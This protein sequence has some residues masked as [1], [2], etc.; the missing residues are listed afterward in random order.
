LDDDLASYALG[1]VPVGFDPA[2]PVGTG[3]FRRNTFTPGDR[4]SFTR[5]DG[6][7][8]G[9][10]PY[11]DELVI[12]D[13]PDDNARVT[14][15][16]DGTVDAIDNIAQSRADAVKAA[17]ANLLVSETGSWIPFTMRVDTAP[18]SDVR[19]RQ[20]LRLI[21]DREEMVNRALNGQGRPGNDL[22]APFDPAYA[23]ELPQRRQDIDQA[24][25]LLRQ[26]G[27]D[28]LA[29]ELKT[30]SGIG[31]GAVEAAQLFAKQAA[32]AGVTVRVDTV[33]SAT[34]YGKDYLAWGFV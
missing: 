25:S 22:Y 6:Y 34:F 5:F 28:S 1:I 17:G 26:A 18:F 32:A 27:Q 8:R 20:A 10:Q 15:L 33:D 19:V 30:S 13:Y 2:K 21:V 12:I 23:R 9:D 14:A 29:V 16:L 11:V 3:P 31:A 24:R 7:W 4:S